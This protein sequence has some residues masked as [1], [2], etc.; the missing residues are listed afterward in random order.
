MRFPNQFV[1]SAAPLQPSC[2]ICF[3]CDVSYVGQDDRISPPCLWRGLL[4]GLMVFTLD[5]PLKSLLVF[6]TDITGL[7]PSFPTWSMPAF[8]NYMKVTE[9]SGPTAFL[10]LPLKERLIVLSSAQQHSK[11]KNA[12]RQSKHQNNSHLE[13]H[14]SHLPIGWLRNPSAFPHSR[15]TELGQCTWKWQ[16]HWDWKQLFTQ[17]LFQRFDNMTLWHPGHWNL[18]KINL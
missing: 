1:S 12:Q 14:P 15:N 17:S 9:S 11:S 2:A 4:P 5:D 8:F 7:H 13:K 10:R 18:P 16:R 3:P 6:S